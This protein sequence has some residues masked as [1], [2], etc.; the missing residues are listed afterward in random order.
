[1]PT[2][3]IT[4]TDDADRDLLLPID[5]IG[6]TRAVS[7][8]AQMERAGLPPLNLHKTPAQIQALIDAALGTGL[9]SPIVTVTAAYTIG[10]HEFTVIANATGGA[11]TVTLPPAARR[12]GRL[13][14]IKEIGG[15][16]DVTVD[17][18]AAETI[19]GAATKLLST[20]YQTL[21]IQSD[22]ANW[23]ILAAGAAA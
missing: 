10:D 14:V 12:T 22:G 20:Q 13:L 1:M 7:G 21:W 16:N 17:G 8:G 9:A 19:D 11:F 15:T 6:P 5:A 2:S 23:H 3:H 18:N 4:V